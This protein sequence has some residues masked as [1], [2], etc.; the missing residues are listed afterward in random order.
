MRVAIRPPRSGC[1]NSSTNSPNNR[2]TPATKNNDPNTSNS[3]DIFFEACL[4]SCVKDLLP[5]TTKTKPNDY[6]NNIVVSTP[7]NAGI[8]SI[9]RPSNNKLVAVNPLVILI[10]LSMLLQAPTIVLLS[11]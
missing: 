1:Q 8:T 3:F 5:N 2:M 9:E 4:I 7:S 6:N 11:N 10:K